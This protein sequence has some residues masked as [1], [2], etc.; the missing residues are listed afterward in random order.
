MSSANSYTGNPVLRLDHWPCQQLLLFGCL[1]K[2]SFSACGYRVYSY[3]MKHLNWLPEGLHLRSSLFSFSLFCIF[4][5]SNKLLHNIKCV[6]GLILDFED[7]LTIKAMGGAYGGLTPLMTVGT[8]EGLMMHPSTLCLSRA[9]LGCQ[10]G[11]GILVSVKILV[12]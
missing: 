11:L 8:L 5:L 4:L 12:T 2:Q 9:H 3:Y 6:P 10:P 1:S 7:T